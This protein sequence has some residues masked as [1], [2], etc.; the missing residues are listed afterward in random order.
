MLTNATLFTDKLPRAKGGTG[1]NGLLTGPGFL[2]QISAGSTFTVALPTFGEIN[3]GA[4]SGAESAVLHLHTGTGTATFDSIDLTGALSALS[5][6]L[7]AAHGGTGVNNSTRTLTVSTNG[8]TLAFSAASSTLTIPAT[9]TAA[10][11][12]TAQTF[13]ADNVFSATLD[14]RQLLRVF[15]TSGS[16]GYGL[17]F[18]DGSTDI[19]AFQSLDSGGTSAFF[20]SANRHF[21]GTNWQQLNA[22]V[23]SSLLLNNNGLNFFAFLAASSAPVT[24]FTVNMAGLMST[25]LSDAATNAASLA[26]ANR[27]STSGTPAVGF[28]SITRVFLDSSTTADQT[29]SDDYVLWATATHASRKARRSLYIYDTAQREWLRG[30]ASGTAAMIG[31]LGA[32]AVVRQNITGVTTGTL[33]QLQAAVRN[34]LTGL[35]NLGPITDST[36]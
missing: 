8:G 18:G 27:H 15:N 23:G 6:V 13:S 17:R 20:F 31:M 14:A 33:A 16:T 7:T 34:L 24:A 19:G 3:F 32:A 9:G 4:A 35:A 26:I 30:E 36:T 22:R 1:L 5:G 12:G 10:L 11:L 21:D 25:Y 29:A 28:G 2:K